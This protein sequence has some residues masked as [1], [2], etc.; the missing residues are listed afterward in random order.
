MLY[1]LFC[2]GGRIYR[3]DNKFV[4]NKVTYL[5]YNNDFKLPSTDDRFLDFIDKLSNSFPNQEKVN[6]LWEQFKQN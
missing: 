4:I 2:R 5:K 1:H 6:Q 3:S